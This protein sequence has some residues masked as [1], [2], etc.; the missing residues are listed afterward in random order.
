[1]HPE[2]C[3]INERYVEFKA[4]V[5]NVLLVW[6]RLWLWV[7]KIKIDYKK[8]YPFTNSVPASLLYEWHRLS[9]VRI[10]YACKL[11]QA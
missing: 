1:M 5:F 8:F 10:Y 3:T 7:E 11:A 2:D 9:A 6:T 4:K